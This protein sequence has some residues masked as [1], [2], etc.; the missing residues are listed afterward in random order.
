MIPICD[1]C[2]KRLYGERR[3]PERFRALPA[4]AYVIEHCHLCSEPT[5]G[6]RVRLE[7]Q[8]MVEK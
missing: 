2:H 4:G 7:Q 5:R 1:G 8:G 6:G 3:Q